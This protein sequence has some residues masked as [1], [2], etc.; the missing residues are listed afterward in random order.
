MTA[1][2]YLDGVEKSLPDGIRDLEQEL[3]YDDQ[4]KGIFLRINNDLTFHGS[5]YD[6]LEDIVLNQGI[7]NQIDFILYLGA[8]SLT[9]Y[10]KGVINIVDISEM[11]VSREIIKTP[12]EDNN[13]GAYVVNN[14]NTKAYINA[15]RNKSGGSG[16]AA[17]NISGFD[18]F[19]P[20]TGT[21]TVSR[22]NVYTVD[23]AFNFLITFMSDGNLTYRSPYFGS[24][25]DKEGL[26]IASSLHI[27]DNSDVNPYLSFYELF[28]EM[29]KLYD[30]SFYIDY[31]SAL[32]EMVIDQTDNI[33]TSTPLMTFNNIKDVIIRFDKE[34]FYSSI[35]IGSDT[36]QS[37]SGGS[38]TVPDVNFLGFNEEKY[39]LI[40]QCNVDRNLDL[41]NKF[42]IDSNVIEDLVVNGNTQYDD[43]VVIIESDHP[44][45]DQATKFSNLIPTGN[46]Y[47]KQ[48][49]NFYKAQNYLGAIPSDMVL[50][51]TNSANNFEATKTTYSLA[52]A[53][54]IHGTEVSDPAGNYD[55]VLG[56][57]TCP[58]GAEGAYSFTFSYTGLSYSGTLGTGA[59]NVY[60][61]HYDSGAVLLET[62]TLITF[63]HTIV[64]IDFGG[65]TGA[66]SLAAG[67]YVEIWGTAGLSSTT[68]FGGST[69]RGDYIDVEGG[70]YATYDPADYK[71]W[72]IE[73]ETPL[74]Q[75]EFE[76]IRDNVTDMVTVNTGTKTYK[77]WVRSLKR[78]VMSGMSKIVLRTSNNS[79][80]L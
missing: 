52:T 10:F 4:I 40:G 15:A 76:N 23:E 61:K 54:I 66:L 62:L 22:N 57:F 55:N 20:S 72:S 50:F 80:V 51:I 47:N 70:T 63:T 42:I 1:K 6:Y 56:I 68:N 77:G 78:N 24:G 18:F 30:I 27:A 31:S 74:T 53:Q 64:I 75:A 16:T 32:P 33:Y 59:G 29:D 7:C 43:Q 12:I 69:F 58:G 35:D 39:Y 45:T 11:N 19:T 60:L 46:M 79:N 65:A 5:G 36:T 28:T 8:D 2:V 21:Y 17:S 49:S 44:G 71:A 48:L 41:V 73:F 37:Y 3:F 67:D 25:G 14:R 38:F 34:R 13:A 9:E 26:A